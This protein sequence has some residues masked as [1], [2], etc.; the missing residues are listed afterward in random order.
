MSLFLSARFLPEIIKQS[1]GKNTFST[2]GLLATALALGT[3]VNVEWA[4]ASQ[5]M[6]NA[7]SADRDVAGEPMADSRLARNSFAGRVS[8]QRSSVPRSISASKSDASNETQM[9]MPAEEASKQGLT[10]SSVRPKSAAPGTEVRIRGAGFDPT[11]SGN[12]VTFGGVEATIESAEA[13]VIYAKVPASPEGLVEVSVTTGGSTAVLASQFAVLTPDRASLDEVGVDLPELGQSASPAWGDYDSD[14]DLDLAA[15]GKIYQNEGDGTFSAIDAGLPDLFR[16]SSDWGDYDSDGDLDLAI[17]GYTGSGAV[18][19]IYRNDGNG[20]FTEIEAG[21]A[22]VGNPSLAWGDYDSDGDL[23]L[24][25]AGE[26][27]VSNSEQK[28][29]T[30]IYRNDGNGTF[31]AVGAG[32]EGIDVDDF[33]SGSLAWGD[34]NSDGNLDL[35]VGGR[36][37]KIYR[38]DGNE[39]FTVIEANLS[40]GPVAWGDYD[41]DGDLDIADGSGIY[42]NGGNGDFTLI[43][44]GLAARALNW[45]DFDGDGDLDIVTATEINDREAFAFFYENR[46]GSFVRRDLGLKGVFKPSLASGDYNSDGALDLVITGN[47]RSTVSSDGIARIYRNFRGSPPRHEI[48]SVQPESATPGSPIRIQGAGFDPTAS[49]NTVTIGGVEATVDSARSTVLYAKVPS[50]PR[51]PA[52]VDVTTGSSTAS[53]AGS[54]SVLQDGKNVLVGAGAVRGG[55]KGEVE[56]G[57]FDQD[58]NVDFAVS[59]NDGG[60]PGTAIYRNEGDG[61]FSAINAGLVGTFRS[62]LDWGDYDSDGDL[63]LAV[64]GFTGGGA[65][66]KIYRND[67]NG[68]FTDIEAGLLGIGEGSVAWGDY[69]SDGDLDLAVGGETDDVDAGEGSST[70]IYRNEGNGTFAPVG[71][72]VEGA[73]AGV[74]RGYLDWVDYDSDGDL[75]L[76]V[77]SGAVYRN[78]GDDQFSRVPLPGGGTMAWADYDSDGDMDLAISTPPPGPIGVFRKDRSFTRVATLPFRSASLQWGD[79]DADRDLDLAVAGEGP[80][81]L[82]AAGVY[83]NEDGTFATIESGL[84]GVEDASV[85]WADYDSD[86]DLDLAVAGRDVDESGGPTGGIEKVT[87]IYRNQATSQKRSLSANSLEPESGVSGSPVQIRGAGFAPKASKNTVTFGGVEAPID[88]AETNVLYARVPSGLSGLVEVTVTSGE[89]K[90]SVTDKFSVLTGGDNSFSELEADLPG[91][92]EAALDWGDYDSDGDLDLVATGLGLG[93]TVIYR[94]EGGGNF[95]KVDVRLRS[96]EVGLIGVVAG[97]DVEWGDY[98]GDG[99]LD[100]A[101]AGNANGP[102]TRIYRNDGDDVF[103]L[104]KKGRGA[105]FASLSW[106]D[107]DSDGD[108]DLVVTGKLDNVSK[109]DIY[110]NDGNDVFTTTNGAGIPAVG[111]SSVSLGDIDGDSDLDVAVAGDGV[112]SVTNTVALNQKGT[113]LRTGIDLAGGPVEFVDYD[114]D[115]RLDLA[116]GNEIY[117]SEGDGSLSPTDAGLEGTVTT[118][119]ADWGDYDGDGDMDLIVTGGTRGRRPTTELNQNN[120]G[121]F[122]AVDIGLPE[123]DESDV[124]WGDFDSDGDLDLALAGKPDRS[125]PVLKIFENVEIPSPMQVS[126]RSS[127]GS[128]EINWLGPDGASIAQHFIYRSDAPIDSSAGP[129]G[130]APIDSVGAGT[131]SYSDTTGAAGTEYYYRVTA[132]D[133]A[134]NESGFSEE[135]TATPTDVTPPSV[136]TGLAATAGGREVNLSWDANTEADL[137]GY[138]LYRSAQSLPDTSGAPLSERLITGSTFTDT[139]AEVGEAYRYAVTAVD[140]AGNESALSGV[141]SAYLQPEAVEASVARTFGEASGPGD[142]RLVALPGAPDT[143]LAASISG[144]AG[145]E[146]QAYREAGEELRRLGESEEEFSFRKGRG[147]WLTSRQEWTLEGPIESAALKDSTTAIPLNPGGWTIVANPFGE[148]VSFSAL[149]RANGGDLQALW[150][151]GGAFSDTSRTFKSAREGQAYYLFSEDPTRDSLQVPHPAL[152]DGSGAGSSQ[153]RALEAASGE[154]ASTKAAS[155]KAAASAMI[156]LSA[157]PAGEGEMGPGAASTV[158]VGL[159]GERGPG[160]LRAPPGGLEAVSLRVVRGGQE[161]GGQGEEKRLLMRDC[162]RA[163]GEGETFR[164]RLESQVEGPIRIQARGADSLGSRSAALIDRSEKTTYDLSRDGPIQI[165]P[166]Q[167]KRRLEV[168]VGSES[169]VEGKREEA[170]PE[171]VRLTSYPNPAGRQATVEYALPEAREVTLQVYDVLGRRVATLEQGR[172]KAGRHTARLETSRLSSGVYFGRLEA[173]GQTRTQKITVVR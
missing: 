26:E 125:N 28:P 134:A 94:N 60:G 81:R 15:S 37:P 168:A 27:R 146:W 23:D 34:Y 67:G 155:A 6:Q 44:D 4:Q 76:A 114:L 91:L 49:G 45:G 17:A 115:G 156:A 21:L 77:W 39:T 83:L 69:D 145:A 111:R 32:L 78:D 16:S 138:Q 33:Y 117:R 126:A 131:T 95:S 106:A 56:W 105:R 3:M 18:T 99:D 112:G 102:V 104:I 35:A 163:E 92:A 158:R 87:K 97:P 124:A 54:F 173:G 101:I 30:R 79:H 43:G 107:Y 137:A 133:T 161:E 24:A 85:D 150:P 128:V 162:R 164:L 142:Y 5:E 90:N 11:A 149:S 93:N 143:S 82:P 130:I 86:G 89:E 7:R 154:A 123:V 55:A 160:T 84:T 9:M 121:S 148:A 52:E 50:E 135:A 65:V 141:A 120:G 100:L 20:A 53:L 46:D 147:Y 10:V 170:I 13:S 22:K 167:E 70:R 12:T 172:K 165:T 47:T 169:Y 153:K 2:L 136:P 66:T 129:E 38:N 122:T 31:A 51:G 72:G 8:L 103:K 108:L 159:A 48:T 40:V 63:D 61:S 127:G 88:S 80:G 152:T 132:V 41:S 119:G 36:N 68:N 98:D 75:D 166:G 109:S 118:G 139:T 59:G 73:G 42:R 151:F 110:R 14:G 157:R 96:A 71:A 144:E 1:V 58:G 113:L 64:A 74:R 57:D 19:K 116:A 29:L 62:S 140:T 25:I 171:E